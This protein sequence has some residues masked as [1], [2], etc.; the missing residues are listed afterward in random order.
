MSNEEVIES[1][2]AEPE[3]L[4]NEDEDFAG[5]VAEM[6]G[7][8][9][10]AQAKVAAPP[11]TEE[12]EPNITEI[13]A[14]ARR[15]KALR[16]KEK[17]VEQQLEEARAS[18]REE[19]MEEMKH[20]AVSNPAKFYADL[21]MSGKRGQVAEDLW[22]EELGDKAP[23]DY[24]DKRLV[25]QM[26]EEIVKLKELI[27]ERDPKKYVEQAERDRN[28]A[29]YMGELKGVGAKSPAIQAA[30]GDQAAEALWQVAS[31]MYEENKVVPSAEEVIDA[32]EQELMETAERLAAV[33]PA[34]TRSVSPPRAVARTLPAATDSPRTPKR[35]PMTDDEI[36]EDA[37]AYIQRMPG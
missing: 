29:R 2:A 13:V 9:P 16:E 24:K 35:E 12:P 31:N 14:L 8:T 23:K 34:K 32:L 4:W 30:F 37:I 19:I 10:A 27:E 3:A 17:K 18:I 36:M 28:Y 15:E 1:V 21:G 7:E 11:Q 6:E 33:A 5:L 20:A 26:Q 25:Q 22:Y